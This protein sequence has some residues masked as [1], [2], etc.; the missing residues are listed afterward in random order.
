MTPRAERVEVVVARVP[1]DDRVVAERVAEPHVPAGLG[2]VD[3]GE[4]AAERGADEEEREQLL[5]RSA[6]ERAITS[7]HEASSSSSEP[8][9]T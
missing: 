9:L 7:G 2:R 4:A 1:A 8:S 5:H 6:V 3:V